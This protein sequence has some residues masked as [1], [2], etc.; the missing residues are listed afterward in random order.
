VRSSRRAVPLRLAMATILPTVMVSQIWGGSSANGARFDQPCHS[1]SHRGVHN[2]NYDENTEASAQRSGELDSPPEGDVRLTS[3]G[4][5]V[6]MH[7]DNVKRTTDGEGKPE[8][9]TL[10]ELQALKTEPNGQ[11]VPTF[12]QWLAAAKAGGARFVVAEGKRFPEYKDAWLSWGLAAFSSASSTVDI[13]VYVAG[14]WGFRKAL[15]EVDAT[16]TFMWRPDADEHATPAVAATQLASFVELPALTYPDYTADE[17]SAL[18][19]AGVRVALRNSN[20]EQWAAWYPLGVRWFQTDRPMAAN[21]WCRAQ[22][23]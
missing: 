20:E 14:T 7:D 13:P 17:V 23:G 1:I 18:K 6:M 8:E 3:D 19:Q 9:M 15:H 16:A 2:A 10:A 5:L 22:T 4:N 12:E 21:R 11:P